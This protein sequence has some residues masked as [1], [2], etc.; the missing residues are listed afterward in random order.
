M[1]KSDLA[2]AVA[3]DIGVSRT[4]AASAVD[5]VFTHVVRSVADG[6]PVTVA[7]FGI[8]EP[9]T[10][11]ARTGR[12]PHTGAA[13]DVPAATVPAFRAGTK[14]KRIVSGQEELPEKGSALGRSAA[15]VESAP[16]AVPAEEP[17]QKKSKGK[18]G[19]G[20]KK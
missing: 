9:R 17:K 19:K 11:A 12:N 7:G 20:K 15:P 4:V 5:S 2:A 3:A 16:T 8:F 18:K 6:T 13:I 14:F 10:R 1:N